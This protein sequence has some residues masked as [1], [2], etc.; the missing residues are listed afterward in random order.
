M[1]NNI[2]TIDG[3][4]GAGKS[5][6]AKMVAEHLNYIHLD[7]GAIYRGFTYAVIQKIGLFSNPY[8]F[9]NYFQNSNIL[10]EEFNLKVKFL[11]NEQTIFLSE[12][13]ITPYLRTK[14]LTERIKFIAD[15]PKYRN[16]V[17]Q[18]LKEIAKFHSIVIDGRDM[19]TEVFPEAKFKF[20]LDANIEE[21]AKRRLK[22]L[23]YTT[24]LEDIIKTIQ[25]RDEED[26]KREIGSLK[27]PTDSI[28]IDTSY[29]SRNM[30]YRL[31][32]SLLNSNF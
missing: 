9:G 7:S 10:P 32:L 6:I 13:N 16:S 4:A 14:E 17:N 27:I 12:N 21:R 26:K 23:N 24:N 2:I 29:L 3:P 5:T 18:I 31:I 1:K 25:K 22:E 30:V 28:I 19:G 11:N 15:H 20:Y 8:E